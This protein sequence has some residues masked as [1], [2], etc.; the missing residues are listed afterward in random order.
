MNKKTK[1][2]LSIIGV[3]A[4]VVPSV[5]LLLISSRNVPA[6]QVS[7]DKR[8]IDT[9]NVQESAASAQPSPTPLPSPSPTPS[10]S[11]EASPSEGT[12]SG[13]E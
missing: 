3:A 1:L 10:P 8:Q 6:P 5:L 11:P 4:I 2:I 13:Q 12:P 7:T 9:K